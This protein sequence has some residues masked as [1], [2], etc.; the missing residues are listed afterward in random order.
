MLFEPGRL[1]A[2][3]IWLLPYF[4]LNSFAPGGVVD[5]YVSTT[6]TAL[7]LLTIVLLAVTAWRFAKSLWFEARPE[8]AGTVPAVSSYPWWTRHL[9]TAWAAIMAIMALVPANSH[10]W[11]WTWS[12]AP[13]AVLVSFQRSERSDPDS[14]RHLPRW[15]WVYTALICVMTMIYHTR[16]VHH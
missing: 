7:Q 11:Y 4:L 14:D 6:R 9:L 5:F 2:H 8:H 12:V 1:F 10:A 13:I 16:V 3:P 15:F